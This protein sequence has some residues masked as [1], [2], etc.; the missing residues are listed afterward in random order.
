MKTC[1]AS[2]EFESAI[3]QKVI[4]RSS[5]EFLIWWLE[6]PLL[7]STQAVTKSNDQI[8]SLNHAITE[9]DAKISELQYQISN[10]HNSTSWRLTSPL[11]T[12]KPAVMALAKQYEARKLEEINAFRLVQQSGA[13][14]V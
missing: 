5:R 2:S 12:I 1:Y 14:D 4:G 13:A 7:T 9:R 3:Q 6:Q 10:L 8:V 11:R